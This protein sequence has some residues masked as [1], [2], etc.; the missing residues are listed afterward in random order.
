MT[1]T[2]QPHV[3]AL[4]APY[5]A[6]SPL[7]AV[8][9]SPPLASVVDEGDHRWSVD[10]G[11]LARC[12]ALLSRHAGA[13][14][15]PAA[16]VGDRQVGVPPAYENFCRTH[17][18]SVRRLHAELTWDDARPVYALALAAHAV[19]CHAL[20]DGHEQ[21][22]APHWEQLRGTSRLDWSRARPLLAD[23]CRA[24]D[25]LDPLAMRR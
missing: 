22:L 5:R 15:V 25:R 17:F 2:V 12:R 23:G 20:E 10:A 4:R 7:S 9:R 24:L 1:A 11:T 19:L 8:L 14:V 3:G 6:S 18:T 13:S 16:P 21:L